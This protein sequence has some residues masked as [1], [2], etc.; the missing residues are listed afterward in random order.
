MRAVV[1][2]VE[3]MYKKAQFCPNPIANPLTFIFALIIIVCVFW[4]FFF[5]C[6]IIIIM[7]TT[8]VWLGLGTDKFIKNKKK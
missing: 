6:A 5:M 4:K 8:I 3:K 7:F 2:V 1:L